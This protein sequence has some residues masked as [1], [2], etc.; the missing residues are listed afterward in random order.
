MMSLLRWIHARAWLTRAVYLI[1]ALSVCQLLA[2]FHMAHHNGALVSRSLAASQV[3]PV[4]VP[5]IRFLQDTL[6][7]RTIFC[8]ALF[9]TIT[10]GSAA[11]LLSLLALE[12]LRLPGA[13][14]RAG[15]YLLCGSW[16]GLLIFINAKGFILFPTAC[17]TLVPLL[18]GLIERGRSRLQQQ[19]PSGR[20]S[21]VLHALPLIAAV[22]W[23]LPAGYAGFPSLRDRLLLPHP[24]GQYLIRVYYRYAFYPASTM[25]SFRQKRMKT[26]FIDR[27]SADQAV[28]ERME[29]ILAGQSLV[30]L[31]NSRWADLLIRQA[32]GRLE[33]S[34]P[35][36]KGLVVSLD[37]FFSD[38]DA[39][40]NEFSEKNDRFAALRL[41]T[42]L[43]LLVAL[44]LAGCLLLYAGLRLAAGLLLPE[45][46]AGMVSGILLLALGL[47]FCVPLLPESPRTLSP[48]SVNSHLAAADLSHRLAAY[49]FLAAQPDISRYL[50]ADLPLRTLHAQD[51]FWL[52]GLLSHSRHRPH[53]ELLAS[54]VGD[55]IPSI[56]CR[57]LRSLDRQ[58]SA[59]ARRLI[60]GV[61]NT[62]TSWY[63]QDCAFAA[64][65]GGR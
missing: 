21:P 15:F 4:F 58:D 31:P 6:S 14:A 62:T 39:V 38:P 16:A 35:G 50:A 37:R 57:A 59:A 22:I 19:S 18:L 61:L 3:A 54:L 44:P 36:G 7:F 45:K 32:E 23:L 55:E 46:Q 9:L 33:L 60:R 40:L 53:F 13:R 25:Q 47:T 8:A 41:L 11:A 12:L 1:V 28:S 43:S 17:L 65:N 27:P 56:G 63:L 24:A 20:T 64:L 30:L 49:R 34:V 48:E 2:Y 42:Y 29:V 26:G 10:I 5:G 51:R 52:A